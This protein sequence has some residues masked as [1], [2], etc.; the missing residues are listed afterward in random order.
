MKILVTVGTSVFDGLIQAVDEQFSAEIFSITLQIAEG[1]YRPVNHTFFKRS[2]DFEHHL[3]EADI[4]ITHGGAGTIFKLMEMEK[5][6]IAVP[7]L[8]RVDPHQLDLA[9]FVEEN[10]YG[11]VCRDLSMLKEIF[12]SLSSFKRKVYQ[13]DAFFMADDIID[14]FS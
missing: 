6:F 11:L 3:S 13:K 10:Q 1:Q 9:Q 5:P 14:Y 12:D 7:N 2:K 4:V 8:E